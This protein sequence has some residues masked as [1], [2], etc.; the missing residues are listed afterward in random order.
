MDDFKDWLPIARA[1]QRRCS[2]IVLACIDFTITKRKRRFI[3]RPRPRQSWR[4]A[5][6]C[7]ARD[8]QGLGEFVACGC[9]LENRTL[10]R[11]IHVLPP[12]SAWTFSRRRAREEGKLLR[13][14]RMGRTRAARRRKLLPPAARRFRDALCRATLTAENASAYRSPVVWIRASSWRGAR[15]PPVI[16]AVLHLRQHVP[17]ESGRAIL[18][19]RVAEICDQ[20]YQ[21][22]TVDEELPCAIR[23]LCRAHSLPD[24]RM[25]GHQPLR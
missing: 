19:R 23:A 3:S 20:P 5:L 16:A 17:R 12:G 24:R 7:A 10:F 25:R 8:P 22:V 21:V 13:A 4:F 9:V 11:G 2:T 15:R 1:A 18:A 6:N 14:A